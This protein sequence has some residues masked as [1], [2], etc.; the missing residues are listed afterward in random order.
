MLLGM[1]SDSHDHEASLEEAFKRFAQR[2][3]T[4]VL[5]AGDLCAPFMI[6]TLDSLAEKFGIERVDV[7]FGNIDDRYRTTQRAALAKRVVLHGDLMDDVIGGKHVLMQHYPKPARYFWEGGRAD[8][9][10]FGHTHTRLIEEKQGRFLVN[11]GEVLGRLGRAS[12]VIVDLTHMHVV[13]V[14]EWDAQRL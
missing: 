4:R 10:V 13:A 3:V 5:H 12:L 1:I 11:P 8:L 14:E 9:V 6:D 2:G 7:V